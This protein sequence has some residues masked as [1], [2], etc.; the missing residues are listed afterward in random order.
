[1]VDSLGRTDPRSRDPTPMQQHALLAGHL[2]LRQRTDRSPRNPLRKPQWYRCGSADRGC[3]RNP[4]SGGRTAETQV[5][6]GQPTNNPIGKK[7]FFSSPVAFART[8]DVYLDT[9]T[10]GIDADLAGDYDDVL[11]IDADDLEEG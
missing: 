7:R 2:R 10:K 6:S 1:M 11:G 8:V 9:R 3:R 5:S 4:R